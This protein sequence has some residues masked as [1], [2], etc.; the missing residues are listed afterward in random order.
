MSIEFSPEESKRHSL[1]IYRNI[2][3]NIEKALIIDIIKENPD[4]IIIRVPAEKS[5]RTMEILNEIG[6]PYHYADTLLQYVVNLNKY[7]PNAIENEHLEFI[8][9]RREHIDILK[10]LIHKVFESY[11]YNHY[12]SNIY[13]N[14]NNV[15]DGYADWI[16]SFIGSAN[17]NVWIIKDSGKYIAFASCAFER[18]K[19]IGVLYGVSPDASGRHIYSDLIRHTQLISKK[20]NINEMQVGTQIQNY[21]VQKAWINE[22]FNLKESLITFHV[23]SFLSSSIF[24]DSLSMNGIDTD[25]MDAPINYLRRLLNL[26]RDRIIT[27]NIRIVN[28][29]TKPTKKIT[30]TIVK[31]NAINSSGRALAS[32]YFYDQS[33][34]LFKIIYHDV[35]FIE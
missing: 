10:C 1:R 33:N 28:L 21:A 25:I 13:I 19:S 12:V 34:D 3:E 14:Q 27:S 20:M 29:S 32:I 16:T 11:N 2:S 15:T 9:C 35:F 22:G 7:I 23:N 4:L 8:E 5:N 30:S 6:F 17:K 31:V 24:E 18:G 26:S